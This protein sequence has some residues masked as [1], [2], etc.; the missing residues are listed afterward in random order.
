MLSC[1]D[2]DSGAT[3][4]VLQAGSIRK[5]ESS[6]QHNIK[7]KDFCFSIIVPMKS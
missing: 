3:M 5:T 6:R 4:R 7:H 1:D 2:A